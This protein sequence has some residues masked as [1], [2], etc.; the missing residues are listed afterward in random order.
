VL[1]P[2]GSLRRSVTVSVFDPSCRWILVKLYWPFHG[3]T[4]L[5]RRFHGTTMFTGKF[6]DRGLNQKSNSKI[7]CTRQWSTLYPFGLPKWSPNSIECQKSSSNFCVLRTDG[8]T[9]KTTQNERLNNK[10]LLA[11]CSGDQQLSFTVCHRLGHSQR[12]LLYPPV[13]WLY[14]NTVTITMSSKDNLEMKALTIVLHTACTLNRKR[15][16]VLMLRNPLNLLKWMV[17]SGLT[18]LSAQKRYIVPKVTK[19]W[20]KLISL[21]NI[22]KGFLADNWRYQTDESMSNIFA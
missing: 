10:D 9:N 12:L 11:Q 16:H 18:A 22:I 14:N 5:Y 6:G 4:E 21:M 8:Q 17:G 20:Y 15:N 19:I 7:L 13:Y 1:S 2:L 3:A